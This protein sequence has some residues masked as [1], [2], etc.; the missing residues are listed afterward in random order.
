MRRLVTRY[1]QFVCTTQKDRN[2]SRPRRQWSRRSVTPFRDAYFVGSHGRR[3]TML[4]AG[5]WNGFIVE[6]CEIIEQRRS[7][8]DEDPERGSIDRV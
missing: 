3:Y 5:D 2:S 7:N 8:Q 4:A 6:A 1:W